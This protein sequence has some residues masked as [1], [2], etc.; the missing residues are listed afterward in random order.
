[1]ESP[2]KTSLLIII[3][4][5]LLGGFLLGYFDDSIN[6]PVAGIILDKK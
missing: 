3:A 1:M 2:K 4:I 6:H 5:L